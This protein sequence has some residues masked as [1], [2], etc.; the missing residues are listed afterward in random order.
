MRL[1]RALLRLYP[2]SYRA[3]Y[4]GELCAVFA[5]RARESSGP[6]APVAVAFAA[7]ADVVPNA[8]APERS[9]I[10]VRP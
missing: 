1:Y 5:E 2:A 8:A 6:L 7:V 9:D 3:E 4:G 10:V